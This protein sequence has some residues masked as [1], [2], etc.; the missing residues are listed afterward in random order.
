V[1][2]TTIS[3]FAK[4]RLILLNKRVTRLSDFSWMSIKKTKE[5]K[6]VL[7]AT[8]NFWRP[9]EKVGRQ[10][11]LHKILIFEISKRKSIF[12]PNFDRPP[13]PKFWSWEKIILDLSSLY[14]YYCLCKKE[15]GSDTSKWVFHRGGESPPPGHPEI[16]DAGSNRV[17]KQEVDDPIIHQSSYWKL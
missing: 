1:D 8:V 6:R 9:A 2:F 13:N 12:L 10:F 15:F 16:S 14:M 5:N 4:L 3:E 17:N 11:F 7:A